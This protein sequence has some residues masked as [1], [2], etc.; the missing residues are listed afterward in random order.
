[1]NPLAMLLVHY[2]D[3]LTGRYEFYTEKAARQFIDKYRAKIESAHLYLIASIL[4]P[5]EET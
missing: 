4:T 5:K 1:M 3:G 2:K